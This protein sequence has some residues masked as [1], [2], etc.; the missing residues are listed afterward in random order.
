MH[1][2]A[3]D[4]GMAVGKIRT[5]EGFQE[6]AARPEILLVI[7]SVKIILVVWTLQYRIAYLGILYI[8]PSFD[9]TVFC[10]EAAEQDIIDP[11]LR[12]KINIFFLSSV[13]KN[14]YLLLFHQYIDDLVQS[15]QE[16]DCTYE[17]QYG[18]DT[19]FLAF[20]SFFS[21]II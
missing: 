12:I 11:A 9:I 10:D 6:Y 21:H 1:V 14:I 16:H 5:V 4:D 20:F 7:R 18:I 13:I 17:H 19:L 15:E 2:M 3:K 8:Y